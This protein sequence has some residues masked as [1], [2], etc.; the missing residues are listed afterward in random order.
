MAVSSIQKWFQARSSFEDRRQDEILKN[1]LTELQYKK[2]G[3]LTEGEKIEA[4]TLVKELVA[5]KLNTQD[6]N[7]KEK[8][9]LISDEEF[10]ITL[11]AA[12]AL[13]QFRKVS[14]KYERDVPYYR[15][16]LAL[17]T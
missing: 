1:H 3:S 10:G 16:S 9:Q 15:A 2:F 13:A 8:G 14:G 6:A 11:N 5:A 12:Q 17:N 7:A 4:I